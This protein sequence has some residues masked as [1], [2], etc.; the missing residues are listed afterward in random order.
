M[1]SCQNI[2]AI[3]ASAF[4]KL[5]QFT[6][7]LIPNL[8]RVQILNT[9]NIKFERVM[10]QKYGRDYLFFYMSIKVELKIAVTSMKKQINI[11][12]HI[13]YES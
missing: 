1:D 12:I 13:T 2:Y 3:A 9:L 4:M 10:Y 8:K 7:I 6:C 11:Y 5:E